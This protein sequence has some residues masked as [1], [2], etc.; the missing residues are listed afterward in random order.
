MSSSEPPVAAAVDADTA[1]ILRCL[2][3][4]S[5]RDV[6]AIDC[7]M[8]GAK[9]RSMLAQVS[10][11]GFNGETVYQTFVKPS[12]TIVDYRT[13]HSGI[14]ETTPL[15]TA[16]EFETVHHEAFGHLTGKVVVGFAIENDL[17]I[18]EL[19]EAQRATFR[20]IDVSKLKELQVP[21]VAPVRPEAPTAPAVAPVA[22]P[23][24]VPRT[25]CPR[26]KMLA[27][28]CLGRKIQSKVHEATE[29]AVATMDV[30][31][32]VCLLGDKV[33]DDIMRVLAGHHA[34][35]GARNVLEAKEYNDLQEARGAALKEFIAARDLQN[36]TE[37][38]YKEAVKV[39]LKKRVIE[40][41][42][43]A[44]EAAKRNAARLGKI[45]DRLS[46]SVSIAKRGVEDARRTARNAVYFEGANLSVVAP[47]RL[48]P[49]KEKTKV[50][51]ATGAT[52]AVVAPVAA[53]AT[54]ATGAARGGAGGPSPPKRKTRRSMA[55]RDKQTRRRN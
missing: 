12:E 4:A 19:T 33:K 22:T 37:D 35:L 10:I 39:P 50:A 24:P 41:R 32:H 42:W 5:P 17:G 20:V 47:I 2:G 49:K 7:E 31:K 29:D 30:L 1:T 13:K 48:K 46:D 23:T 43:A 26:L 40:A 6:V 44:F 53:V 14:D 25:Y 18:L 28:A 38:Q 21:H 9:R 45:E 36:T 55:R 54:G 8:V 51:A 3:V 16:P 52:G 34:S 15:D 27:W 11:V